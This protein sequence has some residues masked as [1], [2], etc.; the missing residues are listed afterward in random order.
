M[1][2]LKS[3]SKVITGHVVKSSKVRNP[4]LEKYFDTIQRMEGSF[5]GFY[6]KI[7]QEEIMSMLTY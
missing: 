1:A 5:Q 6:I 4:T 2:V 7:F 3:D